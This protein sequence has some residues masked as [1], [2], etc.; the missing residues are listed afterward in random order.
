MNTGLR[1][2]LTSA[3]VL[4]A[5][6]GAS[7]W[8]YSRVVHA[9]AAAQPVPPAVRYRTVPPSATNV[10]EFTHD[11]T[12][13][14]LVAAQD[15]EDIKDPL[16]RCLKFPDPP[17][18]HW[19]HAAVVAY[20]KYRNQPLI[21]F[22]QARQLIESGHAAKLDQIL[23]DAL[24]AQQTDPDAV[25]R[26][27]RIYEQ[28]FK[29]GSFAIRPVLDAWK[30]Q[31]PRSAF[32]YAA[33]GLAYEEAAYKARGDKWNT[34]TPESNF[35]NMGRLATL[36]DADLQQ[37]LKLDPKVTPIYPAMTTLGGMA[38][39]R[40][41]GLSAAWKGLEVAPTDL[42]IYDQLMWLEE[43]KWGG[44]LNAMA[45]VASQARLHVSENPLLEMESQETAWYRARNCECPDAE[46]LAGYRAAADHL[47][48]YSVFDDIGDDAWDL[49]NRNAQAVYYSEVLRFKP[50]YT[51][52]RVRRMYTLMYFH[53]PDWAKGEGDRI[54]ASAPDNEYALKARGL[55]YLELFDAAHAERDFAAAV[56]ITPDDD[57]AL[58]RLGDA[59]GAQRKWD[60]AWA[61]AD[62]LIKGEPKYAEGWLLRGEIQVAEPRPGIGQTLAYLDAHFGHDS[63][64]SLATAALRTKAKRMDEQ[65]R[66]TPV[67]PPSS[68]RYVIRH[69]SS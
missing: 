54:L 68:A 31:S 21:A 62:Q 2:T 69:G 48:G 45:K 26:L 34:E 24:R 33:S 16:L 15:A 37:A 23:A 1:T 42:A 55:A 61:V 11:E 65:R 5:V 39:G 40:Q 58:A 57:W 7:W 46:Q 67:Q 32:A 53:H 52:D 28:D 13:Q 29:N 9:V 4:L 60:K 12:L 38:L 56:K 47:V 20:C 63:Q 44:S 59:Y 41:Y 25:G 8:F 14:F 49:G 17:G 36:A 64:V 3:G 18:S 19:N 51:A 43:P 10:H 66:S 22:A 50:E 6:F 27:D 30:R 35:E